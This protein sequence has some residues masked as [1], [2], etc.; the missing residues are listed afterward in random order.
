ML[1][2]LLVVVAMQLLIQAVVLGY[3][4]R[5]RRGE[6]GAVTPEALWEAAKETFVPVLSTTFIAM[7]LFFACG[8]A[9]AFV[10][11]IVPVLGALAVLALMA[12]VVYLFPILTLLYVERVA[13]RDGF[14]EGFET[15]RDYV[16]G[17]WWAT[18]GLLVVVTLIVFGIMM[19]LA[20]P[21]ALVQTAFGF[22]TLEGGGD[23][24]VVALAVSALLGVL[25]YAAYVIPITAAAFQYF[26]LV[27]RK[28][29]TGLL[30]R[31]DALRGEA[32]PAATASVPVASRRA[33]E[34]A[35]DA[36]LSS[37]APSPAERRFRGGGFHDE[38]E[39]PMSRP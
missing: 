24:E 2:T 1:V 8:I 6:A 36:P 28:E 5:Y 19:V 21:G 30:M 7:G 26:S 16:K 35:S 10:A 29:G 9:L 25:V 39:E 34:A 33:S 11:T 15:T 13:E 27:E 20:I 18:F 37:E 12:G 14:W 22:N 31:V 17:H 3:V 4:E 23:V 32:E 38:G